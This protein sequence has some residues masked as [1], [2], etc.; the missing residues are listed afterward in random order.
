MEAPDL[1]WFRELYRRIGEE[2]L[3]FS[4]LQ[5]ADADLASMDLVPLVE[6]YA[7]VHDRRDEGALELDFRERGQRELRLFG[8][9]A[10]LIGRGVGRGADESAV[11]APSHNEEPTDLPDGL[12]GEYRVQ[13][14]QQKYFAS[15]VGQIIST[16]SRHPTPLQGRI[17]IVTDAGWDAVDAAASGAQRDAGRVRQGSVSDQTAR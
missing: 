9:T 10:R 11:L 12:F 17:A 16:N 4:H 14:C 13:P 3:W 8:L 6:I 15:P 7:F 1:D 5:M 2:W